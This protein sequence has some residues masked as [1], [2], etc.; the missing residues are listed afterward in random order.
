MEPIKPL[1][2]AKAN[3]SRMILNTLVALTLITRVSRYSNPYMKIH[4]KSGSEEKYRS[5]SRSQLG[6][7]VN[8]LEQFIKLKGKSYSLS[9]SE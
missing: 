3:W 6:D 2:A 4:F 7:L 9:H 1:F 5:I 8:Y